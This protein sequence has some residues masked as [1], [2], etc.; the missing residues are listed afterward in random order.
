[1][2]LDTFRA[3]LRMPADC[4][5]PDPTA[6]VATGRRMRRR[7]R[8]IQ[9]VSSAA[10][11]FALTAGAVS[12]LG[13]PTTFVPAGPPLSAS[14]FSPSSSAA[15]VGLQP[16]GSPVPTGIVAGSLEQVICFVEVRPDVFGVQ[17][18]WRDPSGHIAPD[19]LGNETDGA[20]DAPGFHAWSAAIYSNGRLL[21]EFGYYVG[22]VDRI[23]RA[24]P[25][26]STV[27]A[28]QAE[29]SLRSD[30]VVFWF[31][32]LAPETPDGGITAYDAAGAV[33]PAGRDA[34]SHG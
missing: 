21:P 6:I 20:A 23:E 1:M 2:D 31:P 12:V 9:V 7:R 19:L 28:R 29:W 18:G 5:P 15:P 27:V 26:G 17:L 14:P 4:T 10:A 16:L 11:V 33:L 25:G 32:D 3:T 22:P 24:V 13:Q 34:L 8:L 30:V